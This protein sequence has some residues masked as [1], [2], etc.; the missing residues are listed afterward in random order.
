VLSF[1][2]LDSEVLSLQEPQSER[3][4]NNAANRSGQQAHERRDRPHRLFA[5]GGFVDVPKVSGDQEWRSGC[6]ST[7]DE[8]EQAD[9][10][11]LSHPVIV[12]A[13]PADCPQDG[14]SG[15]GDC[16][17][18]QTSSDNDQA[19]STTI[20]TRRIQLLQQ[21][22]FGDPTSQQIL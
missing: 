3:H 21:Q 2:W 22:S 5:S 19:T 11:G 4:G 1:W 20:T 17:E 8:G 7:D 18:S 10:Y 13:L 6:H 9:Q 15:G 16:G 14:E 12:A